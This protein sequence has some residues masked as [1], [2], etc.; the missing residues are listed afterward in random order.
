[1][2]RWNH[3]VQEAC[4]RVTTRQSDNSA[5]QKLDVAAVTPP[6]LLLLW[7]LVN[8]SRQLVDSGGVVS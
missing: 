3:L 8:L 2:A 4:C 6:P 7:R 1:M 5:K